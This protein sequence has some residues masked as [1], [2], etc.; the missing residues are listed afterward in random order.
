MDSLTYTELPDHTKAE[1]TK[2]WP[3]D[4]L[5]NE[6]TQ[7][8][9]HVHPRRGDLDGDT[10]VIDGVT[11]THHFVDA[12]GDYETVR[13]HYVEC[14]EGEP[15]VFLHGIPTSWYQFHSQM[16]A[17]STPHRVRRIQAE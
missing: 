15:I 14:G 10:E 3:S 4:E 11:Y 12:P 5:I 8:F 16:S 7:H 1:I 17:L 6:R 13:W 2:L 9:A